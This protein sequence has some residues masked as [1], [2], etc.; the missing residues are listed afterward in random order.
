MLIL[1]N[2]SSK[3]L[4]LQKAFCEGYEY[5]LS[6]RE[7]A[8][9]DYEGL[10]KKGQRDLRKLRDMIATGLRGARKK[11]NQ[12]VQTIDKIGGGASKF[13]QEDAKK[14]AKVFPEYK[15]GIE[16]V[17]TK[18]DD[19]VKSLK[20]RALKNRSKNYDTVLGLSDRAASVARKY[21]EG[22]DKTR[23]RLKAISEV[24]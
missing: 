18:F 20:N 16:S 2:N 4:L 5:F 19:G 13:I 17:T 10:S 7:Y 9:K 3:S 14:I 1:R 11:I 12:P 8:K 6:E 24:M 21:A 23:R 22:K 15:K